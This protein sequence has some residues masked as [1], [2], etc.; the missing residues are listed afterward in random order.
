MFPRGTRRRRQPASRHL[1]RKADF[2]KG[3]NV[4]QRR[5]IGL[6]L[7]IV[8]SGWR[9]EAERGPSRGC[10]RGSAGRRGKARRSRA[11]ARPSPCEGK[12]SSAFGARFVVA[13]RTRAVEPAAGD[14]SSSLAPASYYPSPGPA[15][16]GSRS[17][18]VPQRYTPQI[19]ILYDGNIM[20]VCDKACQ[21]RNEASWH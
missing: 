5:N 6:R 21:H 3:E 15:C 11:D 14:R 10:L 12:R 4:P 9:A 20:W 8:T 17:G 16:F 18:F 2:K 7:A 13:G 19:N 1:R